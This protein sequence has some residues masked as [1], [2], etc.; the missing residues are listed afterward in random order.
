MPKAISALP[1]AS[2]DGFVSVKEAGLR[3][4]L[5]L[6]GDLSD[7]RL[8][9]AVLKVTSVKVPKPGAINLKGAQGA[10]WMSPDELLLLTGYSKTNKLRA[11]LSEALHNSHYLLEV[12]SDA[13][14]QFTLR[15]RGCREVLAK[16]SP[17]DPSAPA[18]GAG[19][20]RRTRTAQVPA[21]FWFSAKD[22]VEVVC[23]RSVADYMFALLK[24]AARPGSEVG[25]F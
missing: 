13:R 9:K 24:N 19:Q 18:F 1:D 2:Y 21:A 16:I 11:D 12:V 5:T 7:A 23:F 15:G 25:F 6:R 22:R 17:A 10:G 20:L 8:Q 3:G 4:M 14:A